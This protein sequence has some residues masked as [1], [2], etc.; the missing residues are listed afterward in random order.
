MISGRFKD[1][2]R[3]RWST[4][5]ALLAVA[6]TVIAC[7][8]PGEAG[9]AKTPP[10]TDLSTPIE[11]AAPESDSLAYTAPPKTSEPTP[12]VSLVM[13]GPETAAPGDEIV[14]RLDYDAPGGIGVRIVWST[15]P[16]LIYVDSHAI[17]SDA[18]LLVEGSGD[19]PFTLWEL[20]G[21]GTIEVILKV[22]ADEPPGSFVV[23]CYEPGTEV[24]DCTNS[25]TTTID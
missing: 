2:P 7:D 13:Q 18:T 3:Q 23:G 9:V 8:N 4:A 20:R 21:G 1:R 17:D 12:V 10:S 5:C 14:Y 6:I 22:P 19:F 24:S 15:N 16:R 11:S 25:V